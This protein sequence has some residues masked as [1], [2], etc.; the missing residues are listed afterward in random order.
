VHVFVCSTLVK[1]HFSLLCP[2][3]LPR[4]K[5]LLHTSG[6]KLGESWN[7]TGPDIPEKR[8]EIGAVVGNR[9]SVSQT[10]TLQPGTM[11]NKVRVSLELH[12][13]CSWTE[14]AKVGVK[15]SLVFGICSGRVSTVP[16]A[17]LTG[18]FRGFSQYLHINAAILR[19]VGRTVYS[20]CISIYRVPTLE[21]YKNICLYFCT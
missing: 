2:A 20:R 11:Q 9:T 16:S 8:E 1:G 4:G 15:F 7:R 17:T 6:K 19:P 3:T 10:L 12:K 18:S 21:V 13:P 14:Q 5:N